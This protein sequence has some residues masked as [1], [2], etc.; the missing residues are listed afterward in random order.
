MC[1]IPTSCRRRSRKSPIDCFITKYL[2]LSLWR[3]LGSERLSD[4]FTFLY[5]K[6]VCAHLVNIVRSLCRPHNIGVVAVDQLLFSVQCCSRFGKL[7]DER[8]EQI[9]DCLASLQH[10]V[11]CE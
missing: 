9:P 7:S 4:D 3:D 1:R 8:L 5:D 2:L 10:F 11:F 6:C